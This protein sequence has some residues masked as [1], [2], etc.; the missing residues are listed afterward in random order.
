LTFFL[1]EKGPKSYTNFVMSKNPLI[2]AVSAS[3]YIL[4]VSLV[5]NFGGKLAPKEDSIFAPVA[6][7]SLFTL[8]AAVMGFLFGYQPFQ[9][10]FSGKK[11]EAVNL[12]LKTLAAFAFLTVVFLLLAFSGIL[13]TR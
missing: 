13:S 11:K 3:A 2:N 10:Y 1:A 4:L 8:S 9:I 7:V 5:L 12:F 6:F